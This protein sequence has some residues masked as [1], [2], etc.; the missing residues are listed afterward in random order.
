V[1]LGWDKR[2]VAAALLASMALGACSSPQGTERPDNS[3]LG[4]SEG[5]RGKAAG[6]KDGERSGDR[7][8][9]GKNPGDVAS[10]T[11]PGGAAPIPGQTPGT[12][13][14]AAKTETKISSSGT[15]PRTASVLVT[16][17]DPDAEKSGIA[18]D[19]GDIVS[20][21]LKGTQ[22]ALEVTITFRAALPDR[23]P[24]DKT[25]MIAGFGLTAKDREEGYAFGVSADTSG[26]KAYGGSAKDDGKFRGEYSVSGNTVSLTLP[27]SIIGGAR[28]I[29][30]YSQA[31][32]FR[33]LAGTTHYSL[34]M[35]P[36]DGPAKYPAG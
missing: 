4:K 16:E 6:K 15:D 23:M 17:P 31:S 30:W 22:A 28:P 14:G 26:W 5:A 12:N 36:N 29:E 25:Y 33:S 2:T 3:L 21:N 1:K 24:D 32:W 7:T 10:Q 34:D 8:T 20:T 18:P 27:W 9:T 13:S 35:L 11:A 19:Y